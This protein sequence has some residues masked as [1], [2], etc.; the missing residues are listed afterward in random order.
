MNFIEV[1]LKKVRFIKVES[2]LKEGVQGE[3]SGG[4]IR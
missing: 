4:M 2:L 3:I 1:K